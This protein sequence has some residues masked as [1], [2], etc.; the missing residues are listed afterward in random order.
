MARPNIKEL[1]RQFEL[2]RRTQGI[3]GAEA[4]CRDV[5]EMLEAKTY[6]I[7]DWELPEIAEQFLGEEVVR[8]MNPAKKSGNMGFAHLRESSDAVS[9]AAFTN[10]TGQLVFNMVKEAYETA[11]LLHMELCDTV[12]TTFL[13]GEKIPGIGPMGDNAEA[14]GEGR[15]YP[16][17]GLN[18]E[19]I[20]TPATQKDGFIIPVTRESV[21]ADRT[22]ILMERAG[23]TGRWLAINKEKKIL[24]TALGI[25][26][27]YIRNG[28]SSNT[29][30]TSGSYINDKTGNALV[31]WTNIEQLELLFD[32]ITS[33]NTNEPIMVHPDT[34]IVPT[35]LYWT[36]CRI[37]R[38][39]QVRFGDGA[40]NSTASYSEVPLS[41]GYRARTLKV[42][43]SP[44]VKQRTSS[45]TKW[46]YG[47]PKKAFKYMEVWGIENVQAPAM[48]YEDFHRDIVAQ[49]KVGLRGTPAIVDPRY[50]VRSAA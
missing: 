5:A 22:G 32:A 35:A 27:T 18:E 21:I 28:T 47:E 15:E 38:A 2:R 9:T 11:P 24:D 48:S 39:T 33:P 45:T 49:F 10:I 30:L 1:K 46:F 8:A 6:K 36:A 43:S 40:S 3:D 42:L 23:E 19:Y 29:F 37:V 34:L 4:F 13:D 41:M 17:V 50:V 14:I 12:K 44:Y 25:T 26:N 31:D 20:Q 16:T 7:S